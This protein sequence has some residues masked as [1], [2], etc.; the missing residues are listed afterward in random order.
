MRRVLLAI[1]PR[2]AA[3]PD[4]IPGKVLGACA[5]QLSFIFKWIFNLSLAQAVIPPCLKTATI[6]PVPKKSPAVSLND[7]RPEVKRFERLVL[8][9]I[10]DCLPPTFD[11]H[12]FAYWANRSTEDAISIALHSVLNHL[13]KQQSYVR[14]LFVDYTSAF[15]T[16]IPDILIT[17]LT[18]L[19]LPTLTGAWIRDFLRN[20]PQ[21]VRLGPH[22]SS[23]RTLSTGSQQGCVLSPLLYCLYTYDCRPAHKDNIIVKFADDTTVVGLISGGMSQPT[24]RKYG[25]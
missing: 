24:E 15:N 1:N 25:G 13:E 12:Q 6:I 14:M 22:L 17:K 5:H 21:N 3:G 7:Y 18:T 20:R 11:P 4:G 9:H 19:H 16:I 8:Q 10:K 2:K 23:T